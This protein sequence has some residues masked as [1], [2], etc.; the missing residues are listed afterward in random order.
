MRPQNTPNSK[1]AQGGYSILVVILMTIALAAV[2]SASLTGGTSISSMVAGNN[3]AQTVVAQAGLI[4]TRLLQCSNDYPTGNNG[5]LY[6]RSFPRADTPTLVSALTCPGNGLGLWAWSDGVSL[7][8]AI[9][10][11]DAWYY[12]NDAASMR[13]TVVSNTS[14]RAGLMPQIVSILGGQASQAGASPTVTLTWVIA[15]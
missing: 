2:L 11:F 6:R 12:T 1:R 5:G 10:G 3:A 13:I 4:R 8:S 7:P 15:N 9:S 14:D